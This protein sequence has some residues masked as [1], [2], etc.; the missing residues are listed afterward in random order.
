METDSKVGC[1]QPRSLGKLV[2]SQD[3]NPGPLNTI[4]NRSGSEERT[5]AVFGLHRAAGCLSRLGA[6]AGLPALGAAA[7]SCSSCGA[8]EGLGR[9]AACSGDGALVPAPCP[10]PTQM[11]QPCLE[12][13][14]RTGCQAGR[15]RG[16]RGGVWRGGHPWWAV[17]I[18]PGPGATPAR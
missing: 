11:A 3:S 14:F 6:Q 8:G 16:G 18:Q 2:T 15:N 7:F 10:N 17:Y 13:G 4:R 1:D 5:A 12:E 9:G